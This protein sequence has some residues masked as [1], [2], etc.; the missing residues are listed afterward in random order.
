MGRESV[1]PALWY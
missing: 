1:T